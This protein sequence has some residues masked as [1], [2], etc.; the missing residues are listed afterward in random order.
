[1]VAPGVLIAGEWRQ[2]GADEPLQPR[3]PSTGQRTEPIAAAA[4]S[5]VDEAVRQAEAAHAGGEW[6]GLPP[7]QRMHMLAEAGASLRRDAR[8]LAKVIAS[9]SGMPESFARFIEVPLAAD[10]LEHF[11]SLC[12]GDEG[13]V[14][15]FNPSSA[16]G[17]YLTFT[18]REPAGPAALITPWNFP[19]LIPAWKVGAALAAGCP[20]IL[21]PSPGAPRSAAALGNALSA[22]GV[23][24]GALQILCGGD[25]VGR[26]LVRHP[27]TPVISFT[28]ST[29]AGREVAGTA[30][31]L[32]KR[33]SL[34]L[35]GK[36]PQVIFADADLDEAVAGCLFGAFW[37]AGQ[38]CQAGSRI[39]V[40]REVYPDFLERLVTAAR[41]LKVGAAHDPDTDVG[42][43]E[44]PARL[45]RLNEAV[46]DA[47]AGGARLLLGGRGWEDGGCYFEPT[48]LGDARPG[49]IAAREELFGP[50]VAVLPF[51][52]EE[53]GMALAN[54]SEYGLAAG[55]WTR[56]LKRAL[57]LARGV[58]AGVLWLNAYLILS[59]A[60][61]VGGHKHSGVGAEMGA[62]ALMP[63]LD[64]K[65]VVTDLNR[66]PPRLF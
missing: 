61:S 55:V 30:G 39:L 36:S 37:H 43:V 22:A 54:A 18:L 1:M 47:V 35:S 52:G 4:A 46:S 44:G 48:V 56:D 27:G 64:T 6:R 14:V 53:E 21:K 28:G 7:L 29:A 59:P 5:D 58:Q 16:P 65:T 57:R 15:A 13:R 31:S 45:R 26:A 66:Q 41:E 19:L 20:A 33:V 40:E 32:L 50:V 3:N 17:D 23:A 42:P 51:S 34:Q 2:G 9:E 10:V 38:V 12:T 8:T 11:A 24:G 49:M 60:V 25:D 63:F 62:D